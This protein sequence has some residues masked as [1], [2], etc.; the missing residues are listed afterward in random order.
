MTFGNSFAY[1]NNMYLGFGYNNYYNP[2][3]YCNYRTA[4]PSLFGIPDFC[5][6]SS[7]YSFGWS[8]FTN[9]SSYNPFSSYDFSGLPSYASGYYTKSSGYCANSPMKDDSLYSSFLSITSKK[10]SSYRG[11]S[12]A[13]NNT[14]RYQA[15]SAV[16][17]G[18][19]GT[20]D[21]YV[22]NNKKLNAGKLSNLAGFS[23]NTGM[24]DMCNPEVV[25]TLVD[26][27]NEAKKHG[28][29]IVVTSSFRTYAKQKQL[30]ASRGAFGKGGYAAQP[31]T[32]PHEYGQAI[33]FTVIKNGKKLTIS[34][35]NTP[36][37]LSCLQKHNMKWGGDYRT[38]KEPWHFNTMNASS[39]RSQLTQTRA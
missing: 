2:V 30:L 25:D 17:V 26:L 24:A 34:A 3:S 22:R 16:N 39:Y 31:G 32:S 5:S 14:V 20:V 13:I 18:S 12:A 36:W 23:D 27:T 6:P 19:A 9:Y 21:A 11:T 37:V 38:T 4:I 28:C 35:A 15:C 29:S 33:D 7:L 1:Y 8:N 10:Y